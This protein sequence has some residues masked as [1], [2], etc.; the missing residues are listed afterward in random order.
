MVHFYTEVVDAITETH[1][2]D[3]LLCKKQD[4]QYTLRGLGGVNALPRESLDVLEHS[5]RRHIENLRP[6]YTG[7]ISSSI[8]IWEVWEVYLFAGAMTDVWQPRNEL[9]A[10]S[11]QDWRNVQ[12]TAENFDK[13]L[14]LRGFTGPLG[15]L[16]RTSV[17][18]F[19]TSR[20][21]DSMES[22]DVAVAMDK[23]KCASETVHEEG[24]GMG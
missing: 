18:V 8:S 4:S 24:H 10:K 22:A 20:Y 15:S 21:P 1:R 12:L 19:S 5:V 3:Y 14:S 2:W 13:D 17:V 6:F 11:L 9:F 7:T 23:A 16:T